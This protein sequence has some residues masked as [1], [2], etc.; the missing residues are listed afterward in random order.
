MFC[1][2]CGNRLNGKK[3]CKNCGYKNESIKLENTTELEK[4]FGIKH[5]NI[6]FKEQEQNSSIE[7]INNKNEVSKIEDDVSNNDVKIVEEE[8]YFN[9]RDLFNDDFNN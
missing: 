6:N 3:F 9:Y 1:K 8:D 2:N 5:E 4:I 7:F